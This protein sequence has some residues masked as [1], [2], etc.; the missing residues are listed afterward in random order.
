MGDKGPNVKFLGGLSHDRL[1]TLYRQAVAVIVP[2][3]CYEV[4]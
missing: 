2:S 4:F 1:Q 3:I